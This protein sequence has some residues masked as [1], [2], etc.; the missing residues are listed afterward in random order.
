MK[1]AHSAVYILLDRVTF[2]RGV[3]LVTS[4]V[5][6][7]NCPWGANSLQY[8]QGSHCIY[9]SPASISH[10][11]RAYPISLEYDSNMIFLIF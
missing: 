4:V 3:E 6:Y 1:V 7:D 8:G 11:R 5:Y 9:D 2:H 10:H